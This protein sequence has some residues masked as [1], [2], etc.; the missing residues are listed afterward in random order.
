ML[1]LQVIWRNEDKME[2][3]TMTRFA[4][5]LYGYIEDYF[6]SLN[7]I[8]YC[9][10]ITYELP[11]RDYI[12][13]HAREIQLEIMTRESVR[14]YSDELKEVAKQY[15]PLFLQEYPEYKDEECLS[16]G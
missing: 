1:L 5:G 13:E 10:K 6:M 4:D 12:S 9:P 3:V 15:L 14:E 11:N 16:I 8:V 2:S 7:D